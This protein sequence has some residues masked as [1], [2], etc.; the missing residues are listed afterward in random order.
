MIPRSKD[1]FIPK[2]SAGITYCRL[3]IISNYYNKTYVYMETF[4]IFCYNIQALLVA[5]NPAKDNV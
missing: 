1:C 2:H 3:I 4:F 5:G